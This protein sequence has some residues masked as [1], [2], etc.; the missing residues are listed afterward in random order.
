M[1][2]LEKLCRPLIHSVCEYWQFAHFGT[3]LNQEAV[4]RDLR[5]QLAEIRLKTEDDPI[6]R[7]EFAKIEQPLVFF[8]DY[9]VKEGPFNFKSDWQEIARDYDELSGDEK[10]FD[11]LSETL[12]DPDA[13]EQLMLYYLFMGLG[14]DGCQTKK[15]Y[16]E[17]RMKLCATR[18]SQTV[19]PNGKNLSAPE[20]AIHPK[21]RAGKGNWFFSVYSWMILLFVLM[22]AALYWNILVFSHETASFRQVLDQAVESARWKIVYPENKRKKI[23]PHQSER[24]KD[25]GK[26]SSI[27][28]SAK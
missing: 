16:I 7:K 8:I 2:Q 6:L 13:A 18:F 1:S 22:C 9:T 4:T 21:F 17:R 3:E 5:N 20:V 28:R 12:D 26:L 14:F 24:E 15:E 25:G 23:T 11:M 27:P 19:T 10:F